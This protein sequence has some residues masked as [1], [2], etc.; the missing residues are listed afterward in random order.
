M[1]AARKHMAVIDFDA[2]HGLR[3]DLTDRDGRKK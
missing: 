2:N 3:D 1:F